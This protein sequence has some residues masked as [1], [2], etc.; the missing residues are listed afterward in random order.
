VAHAVIAVAN[1]LLG[2]PLGYVMGDVGVVLAW[3]VALSSGSIM[4]ALSYRPLL[5]TAQS[6][7]SHDSIF[8]DRQ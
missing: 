2:I 7:N 6:P 4:I 3:A 5:D 8:R 1:L